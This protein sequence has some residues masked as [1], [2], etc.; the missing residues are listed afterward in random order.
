MARSVAVP[1]PAECGYT[2]GE[3]DAVRETTL[4]PE[5]GS[6]ELRLAERV[7]GALRGTGYGALFG[8]EVTVRWGIVRLTGRVPTYHLKQVAQA[9]ALGVAGAD[10][11][12]N[13]LDVSGPG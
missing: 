13:D 4:L 3:I 2:V 9:T 8:V 12:R 6:E 5:Q 10:R 11:V 7:A 1:T